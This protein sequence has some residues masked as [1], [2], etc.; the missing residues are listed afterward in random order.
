M[1]RSTDALPRYRTV[2]WNCHDYAVNL[3]ILIMDYFPPSPALVKLYRMVEDSKSAFCRKHEQY[4]LA[5]ILVAL[6]IGSFSCVL[7]LL[8]YTSARIFILLALL[9]TTLCGAYYIIWR[10]QQVEALQMRE[11]WIQILAQRFPRLSAFRRGNL[12]K[13]SVIR[14]PLWFPRG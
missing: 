3:A 2:F 8:G 7:D 12:V 14:E 13:S 10:L 9:S 6:C 4:V 1:D 11:A 5:M